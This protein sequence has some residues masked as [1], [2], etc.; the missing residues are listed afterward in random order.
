MIGKDYD[1]KIGNG[2]NKDFKPN[3]PQG[4]KGQDKYVKILV[5]DPYNN[6]DIILK[7]TK[8]QKGV[9][10]W[11]TLDGKSMYVGHSINLYNRISSY[12][13]P[14][15]LNTKARRVLRYLNKY[16]FSNIK[17]T[18]YIMDIGS[19]LD[20]VVALEQHFIDTLKPNLN[21]DLVASPLITYCSERDK[22]LAIKINR[23]KSGIYR[24][25]NTLTGETYV[26]SAVNL[27]K[28]FH[29]YFNQKSIERILERSNSHILAAILKYGYSNFKLE[30]LE[31]CDSSKTI[32]REQ[33]YLDFLYPEYNILQMAGSSLGRVTSEQTKLKISESL[34][35]RSLSEEVKQKMSLSQKGRTCSEETNQLFREQ[36]L[37]KDSLFLGKKHTEETQLKMSEALGD[38]IEVFNTE[39]KQTM[40][41]NSNYKA[42]EALNCS[43]A[44]I[45]YYVKKGI[46]YKGIHLLQKN[47]FSVKT[48]NVTDSSQEIRDKLRKERGTPI[49]V[50]ESLTLN[51]LHVF[52]S[53]QHMYTSIGIH[54]KTLN[55]CLDL[56]T[57]YLDHFF[58][59]LDLLETVSN[60]Q[61]TLDVLRSDVISKR[62][63]YKFRHPAAK[64]ILA[65]FK[66]D[67][68]KNLEFDSLNSLAK[69]LK[70]DRKVIRD[71]LKG[72]KSGYYR[73]IWKFTYQNSQI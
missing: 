22:E 1:I 63:L 3:S 17:L 56:G 29:I 14:S 18:L 62:D 23:E 38:K 10:V 67:T 60:N 2:N 71:Y 44:T 52:G 6:R 25:V 72:T 45:R 57:L 65:E 48:E 70:G 7:I 39:T 30:I 34:S 42:A 54:H 53:K 50:Y 24:W 20:Q 13:M 46:L 41:Y 61:L 69:H 8:K 5:E 59:S 55:D 16:G 51:L 36:R 9:Y 12:F 58:L 37:G 15:I 49:Y 31:Y 11:E 33:Y 64:G 73:G 47:L 21:V 68:R 26:G 32:I 27:S 40:I 43:E 4:G 19:S 35:G 66:D 28:R